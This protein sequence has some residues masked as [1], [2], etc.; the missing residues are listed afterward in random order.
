VVNGGRVSN[1]TTIGL[2][3]DGTNSVSNANGVNGNIS[4]AGTGGVIGNRRSAAA[5]NGGVASLAA[6]GG[7]ITIGNVNSGGNSGNTVARRLTGRTSTGWSDAYLV[8]HPTAIEMER[9]SWL[10]PSH[11]GHA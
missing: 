1:Q 2:S 10:A 8:Q 9:V 3:A 6:N 7:T 5:G 4:G 11:S